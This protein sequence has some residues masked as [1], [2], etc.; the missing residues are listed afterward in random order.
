[1]KIKNIE[2]KIDVVPENPI[3]VNNI[4]LNMWPGHYNQGQQDY[5]DPDER[6]MGHIEDEAPTFDIGHNHYLSEIFN[7]KKIS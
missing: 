4:E 1:M 3:W 7:P 6:V 2:K 5:V